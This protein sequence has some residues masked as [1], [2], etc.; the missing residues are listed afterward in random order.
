MNDDM[1]QK[2]ERLNFSIPVD[3][4][5]KQVM[6]GLLLIAAGLECADRAGKPSASALVTMLGGLAAD[7]PAMARRMVEALAP[8]FDTDVQKPIME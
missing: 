3:A 5:K 8:I 4:D 1:R 6:R 2:Y 7:N